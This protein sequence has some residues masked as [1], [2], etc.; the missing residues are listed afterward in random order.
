MLLCHYSVN[1]WDPR[2]LQMGFGVGGEMNALVI[3]QGWTILL[4][5]AFD[6]TALHFFLRKSGFTTPFSVLYIDRFS[7]SLCIR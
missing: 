7:F 5:S 4:F 3:Y 2:R 6:R 1:S